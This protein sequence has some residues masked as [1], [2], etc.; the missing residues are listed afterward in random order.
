MLGSLLK[1]GKRRNVRYGGTLTVCFILDATYRLH[2]TVLDPE[3]MAI[4]LWVRR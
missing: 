4:M 3:T 2:G 1:L